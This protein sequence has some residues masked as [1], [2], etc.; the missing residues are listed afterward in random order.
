MN[1]RGVAIIANRLG[2]GRA[3]VKRHVICIVTDG[4]A[5]RQP[6]VAA[7]EWERPRLHNL[8]HKLV[9]VA[10]LSG[11][12][13]ALADSSVALGTAGALERAGQTQDALKNGTAASFGAPVTD[14]RRLFKLRW[15][16]PYLLLG[17]GG[18][19]P[20]PFAAGFVPTSFVVP[21][22]LALAG[23]PTDAGGWSALIPTLAIGEP[24][25]LGQVQVGALSAT[26]GHG[27]LVDRY[28]NSPDGLARS[29]GLMLEG[30]LAGLG[31]Q[32]ILND[33][34]QPQAFSATRL[35]GRPLIWFLAPD[36]TLQPNE[37]DLD[38]RTEVA[39]IWVTGVSAVVDTEAPSVDGPR[40]VWA[41]GFDNEAALLDNQIVKTIPYLDVNVLGVGT[42]TGF[43]VH[44]GLQLMLDGGGFR[45]DALTEMNFGGEGYVPRYFDRLYML[46][47]TTAFGIGKPK[48]DVAR[49]ASWGYQGRLSA[50]YMEAITA[51]VEAR[52][53]LPFDQAQGTGSGQITVGASGFVFFFGGAVTASQTG[54]LDYGHPGFGGRGFVVTAEGRVALAANVVHLVGR[55]WRAH[56][57]AGD[58]PDDFVI[59]EGTMLGLEVN[60]DF[61]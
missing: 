57:A 61:L 22:G 51:F 15:R 4:A 29:M 24:H 44:P 54:I 11:S 30:N 26:L 58:S 53:Q 56:E 59:N 55:W 48:L 42:G 45:V 34:A 23:E 21:D 12:A 17:G 2:A 16:L 43:G 36:A 5:N 27:S 37:V 33:V 39:G 13:A 28:T 7:F 35:Y 32:L 3:P 20:S 31:G 50:G 14:D 18:F 60:L 9:L 1:R 6:S 8:I 38:P 46:E 19:G 41:L 52:D 49:P 10:W 47:R 40:R 25:K